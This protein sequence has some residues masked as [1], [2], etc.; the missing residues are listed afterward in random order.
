MLTKGT[1]NKPS[2]KNIVYRID[3][4]QVNNPRDV[5]YGKPINTTNNLTIFLTKK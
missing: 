4:L 3:I 5:K 2:D 1:I